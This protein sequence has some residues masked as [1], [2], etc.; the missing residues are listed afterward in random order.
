MSESIVDTGVRWYTHITATEYRKLVF[1][2]A[3]VWGVLDTISTYIAVAVYGDVAN[4]FNPLL[5]I[6]M[7]IHP[8]LL[9]VAKVVFIGVAT[10][11]SIWGR[12]YI[13]S[14]LWWR[15]FFYIQLISGV[16]VTVTNLMSAYIA[17]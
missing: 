7:E 4:E 5:R 10:T 13:V 9:I 16:A 3:F 14:V 2:V 17:L 15:Y 6:A 8:G 11:I 12:E 1:S